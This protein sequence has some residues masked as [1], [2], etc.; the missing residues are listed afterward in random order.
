MMVRHSEEYL[1]ATLLALALYG[2][3]SLLVTGH[4]L[5]RTGCTFV[6][7]EYYFQAGGTLQRAICSTCPLYFNMADGEA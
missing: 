4:S 1:A 2:R 6:A 7:S 5:G 3:L